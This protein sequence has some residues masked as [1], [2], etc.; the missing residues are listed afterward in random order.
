MKL[1]VRFKPRLVAIGTV[2]LVCSVLLGAEPKPDVPPATSA[3]T[4]TAPV[5][6]AWRKISP[7][8]TLIITIVNESSLQTEFKVSASGAILF[9][10]LE[11]VDVAG[12]T[13][14]ELSAKLRELLMK[15]Y[16]VDPQV[17][18]S[19]KDYRADFVTVVGQVGRPGP[20][21][22][23]G[24]RKYDILEAI[25]LAGGTTRLASDTIEYTHKGMTRK[26]SYDKIKH[27]KDPEKRIFVEAGD[28]I[29]VKES[30]M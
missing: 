28:I 13:P 17:L 1:A 26:L 12:L 27:E 14:P 8:D 3:Q 30:W 24:E 22:L 20:V 23:T 25:A 2:G 7:T 11:I 5:R 4:T 19:V 21:G 6:E 15:D 18:V 29:E 16:F 9:P 10:F